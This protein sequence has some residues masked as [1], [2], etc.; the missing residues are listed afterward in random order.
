[1]GSEYLGEG[2]RGGK[3]IRREGRDGNKGREQ[4]NMRHNAACRS[5]GGVKPKEVKV[6]SHRGPASLTAH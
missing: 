3:R 2:G 1:M 4:E 5:R 6:S